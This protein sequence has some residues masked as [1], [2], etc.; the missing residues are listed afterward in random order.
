MPILMLWAYF[1][2]PR[3]WRGWGFLFVLLIHF[4]SFALEIGLPLGDP[5]D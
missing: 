1:A 5:F 2:K 4:G 3:D